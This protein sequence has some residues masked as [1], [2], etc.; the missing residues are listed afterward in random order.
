MLSTEHDLSR[1]AQWLEWIESP[2]TQ[3]A[4]HV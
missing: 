2:E 3:D 4:F 1:Y